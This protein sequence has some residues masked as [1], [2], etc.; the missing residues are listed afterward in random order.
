MMWAP[1]VPASMIHA[2]LAIGFD[3]SFSVSV[4]ANGTAIVT[5]PRAVA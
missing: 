2:P 4:V 3:D 5:W 1:E